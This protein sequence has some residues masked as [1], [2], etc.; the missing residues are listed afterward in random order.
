MTYAPYEFQQ[1]IFRPLYP[2]VRAM[3]V[4]FLGSSIVLMATMLY[5]NAPRWLDMLGR[6]V[7]GAVTAL[8]WWVLNV[9][10]GAM[11]GILLYP[12]LLGGLA[13]EAS[14]AWRRREVFRG[15]VALVATSFGTLMLVVPERFPAL[16]YASLMPRFIPLGLFLML[17]GLGLLAPL[18]S[19]WPG[20]KRLLL[21]VVGLSFCVLAWTMTRIGSGPAATLYLLF[22]LA[23]AAS[24]LGVRPRAPRSVG[25]KLLR[26]LAFA[27]LVPMLALGGVAAFLA[28]RAIEQQVRDDTGRAASGEAHFLMRYVVDAREALQLSLES[29]GFYPAFAARSPELLGPHLRN[30]AH[31]SAFE[32]ALVLDAEG[33]VLATSYGGPLLASHFA[34]HDFHHVV[35]QSGAAY[36]SRPFLG[37]KGQ[38]QVAVALPFQNQGQ[39]EGM[40]VGL[41]SLR[42][43]S[44][45]VT[46]AAQ[47]FRVQV[48]DQ[49]GQLL[50]R[51]TEPDSELLSEAQVPTALSPSLA[52]AE[53][54][55]VEA[56]G[57]EHGR[58]LAAEA[59]VEGTEWKVVVTQDLG[60][61]YRTITRTS[62]AFVGLLAMGVV[63]MFVLSQF[64]ARDVIRRLGQLREATAVI[65]RGDLGRRV[66]EE[67]DDE[68]G[69][70][71]RSFNDMAAR[72]EVA[73]SEL[74]E[75]VRAREEFLSV[76]SHELRTPLTPLKGFAALTLQRMEK[77]E[78]FPDRE[79]FLKALRS[80][81]RQTD[82][83]H[84]LVDD[85]LDTSRIQAG[86]FELERQQV[87]LVPLV[88]EV[89]ERFELRGQEGLRFRFE[90][91]PTPVEGLWDGPRLEQVVTNLLSNAVRYS[92]QGGTVQVRFLLTSES[93]EL[94]VRDEGIGI[95]PESLA[96]LFQ[97]FARASN[98]TSRHFGGLGLGLFICREIV[99]RH[100]GDIWAE[101]PG[102]HRGSSFHV[103]LP[104][105]QPA[106]SP[107]AAAG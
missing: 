105:S 38:P 62:V 31:I 59:R 23:C 46:P 40:L 106:L 61:A 44:A 68:L 107:V 54:G 84:R 104:R 90:M 8:Y 82:R 94:Q 11:T 75:A 20:L 3:G 2:Y 101:S 33:Q 70:L 66:P 17:G 58:L 95:P 21:G 6:I 26:G 7:F 13:L 85:L 14:A 67:E 83:L 22:T 96:S 34:D 9:R 73:Q 36:I 12:L 91:P 92:P 42:R 43:L 55:V 74:R 1:A 15:V 30:I 72:T 98:A 49:R 93:A 35:R 102:P 99:Q 71:C 24:A 103:R 89:L 25:W 16:F 63:L 48:V 19:R 69:E 45:A 10:T 81:S 37:P 41:L 64:V 87:D 29:P 76:A 88:R 32:D 47:R 53:E 86:R 80:M 57:P 65:A 79:R 52:S 4:A 28:Q 77:G 97:P 39:V 50:L 27:G 5:P 51:D 100:G 78:D 60:V 18:E 56:F